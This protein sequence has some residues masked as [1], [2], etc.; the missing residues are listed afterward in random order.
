MDGLLGA[1]FTIRAELGEVW[2]G[3]RACDIG[4]ESIKQE[5][6]GFHYCVPK[7]PLALLLATSLRAKG[8]R[9]QLLRYLNNSL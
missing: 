2:P 8:L 4:S 6:R 5:A 3:L 1:T 7:A 9:L